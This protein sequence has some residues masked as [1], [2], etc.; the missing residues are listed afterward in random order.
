MNLRFAA[1][2][3][4]Y[5]Y[6]ILP[7]VTLL[8]ILAGLG[9]H[10]L[11]TAQL[12]AETERHR[13]DLAAWQSQ[14]ATAT[15]TDAH[16]PSLLEQRHDTFRQLL[17]DQASMPEIVRTFFA[18]ANKHRLPIAQMEYKLSQHTPGGYRIYRLTA[19]TKGSYSD[20]RLFAEDVLA[21]IPAAALEEIG[22][23]REG[24][25]SPSTEAKLR[26]A[27]YLKEKD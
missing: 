21:S 1:E 8:L 24:A 19:P 18:A 6:G 12:L 3:W 10:F 15:V 25:G 14:S 23:K 4:L 2:V 16:E 27:V 11:G 22:F 26:F 5:R 7:V 20:I 17:V 13:L 9:L